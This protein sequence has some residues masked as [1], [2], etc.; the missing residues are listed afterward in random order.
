MGG[1]H[2][3]CFGARCSSPAAP[4]RS[5]VDSGQLPQPHRIRRFHSF[6]HR[7]VPQMLMGQRLLTFSPASD[8]ICELK[9]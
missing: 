9:C 4:G 5:T 6:A 8:R 7:E 1:G 3:G 2:S